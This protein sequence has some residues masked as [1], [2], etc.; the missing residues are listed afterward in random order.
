MHEL[1]ELRCKLVI[2]VLANIYSHLH[3]DTEEKIR[4]ARLIVDEVLRQEQGIEKK[5]NRAPS[6][7]L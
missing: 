5:E 7:I 1:I 4:R 6:S 3:E 2:M